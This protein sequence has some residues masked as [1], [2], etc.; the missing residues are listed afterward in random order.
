MML[1]HLSEKKRVLAVRS[2]AFQSVRD[3]FVARGFLE[4][5]TPIRIP[6]PALELHIDAEPS[7]GMYLRTSPEL[8]MKRLVAAGYE[9]VFQIGACFRHGERGDLHNPEYTMLEWYRAGANYIDVLADTKALMAHVMKDISGGLTLTYKGISIEMLPLWDRMTVD[10]AFILH[11][12]WDPVK[13]F[14]ADRFDLDLVEK[15][16]PNFPKNRPIVL[17]DYPTRAAALSRCKKDHPEIAERWELYIGGIE[18]A[19]AFSELTDP[20][21][22]RNRFME[23]AG[24]R[25]EMGREVYAL[26]EPFLSALEAGMPECAGVALG[27]DRLVMLLTDSPRIDDVRAFC[28]RESGND[29]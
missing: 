17:M 8:H 23:C 28:A 14:N 10:D 15:V 20:V 25:R 22:Q 24:E 3:F 19:N 11:A 2:K 4:V 29:T 16:E 27:L 7:A 26:D 9:K 13:N 6:T 12:G 1:R 18:I 5:E 21:E